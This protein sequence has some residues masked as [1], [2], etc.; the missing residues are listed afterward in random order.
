MKCPV[1]AQPQMMAPE[2]LDQLI[3][4]PV[5]IEWCRFPQQRPKLDNENDDEHENDSGSNADKPDR[6]KLIRTRLSLAQVDSPDPRFLSKIQDR[7]CFLAGPQ[8]I[9][10]HP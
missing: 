3:N 5:I 4:S 6:S 7:I 10:S 9:T 2:N 8:P 1:F